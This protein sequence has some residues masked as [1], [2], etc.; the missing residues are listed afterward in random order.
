MT[1][2]ELPEQSV[3]SDPK[4]KGV[5]LERCFTKEGVHPY[6]EIEWERRDAKIGGESGTVF[7]QK[8]VEDPKFWSMTATNV[9]ASKY[10]HGNLPSPDRDWTVKQ[11]DDRAVVRL[12]TR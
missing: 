7:E 9:A 6:D 10:F 8:G 1:I 12:T 2:T 5:R 3:Q 11:M 4:A